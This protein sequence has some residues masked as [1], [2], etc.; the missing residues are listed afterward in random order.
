MLA[1]PIYTGADMP[2]YFLLNKNHEAV[3]CSM[4]E[5]AQAYEGMEGRIVQKTN[6]GNAEISTVFLGLNHN[7]G[8]GPPAIFESMVFGGQFDDEQCRYATWDE[9][10]TGHWELV[11]KVVEDDMKKIGFSAL[12][13]IEFKKQQ[14]KTGYYILGYGSCVE[15]HTK[16]IELYEKMYGKGPRLYISKETHIDKSDNMYDLCVEGDADDLET[17]ISR[18]LNL[19]VIYP[20]HKWVEEHTPEDK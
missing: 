10:V 7:F 2:E 20:Y 12:K 15:Y 19:A 16:L 18:L 14:Y 6:V 13:V 1:G 5:W 17:V 8:Q 4:L 9:A 3:P 11:A